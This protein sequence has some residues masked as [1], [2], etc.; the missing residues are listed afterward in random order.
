MENQNA[1]AAELLSNAVYS[2]VQSSNNHYCSLFYGDIYLLAAKQYYYLH[3]YDEMARMDEFGLELCQK[4]AATDTEIYHFLYNIKGLKYLTDRE[5]TAAKKI[6]N[7][8]LADVEKNWGKENA[9]YVEYTNNLAL[10]ALKEGRLA[11]A[12]R[13]LASLAEVQNINLSPS[14]QNL[15][16]NDRFILEQLTADEELEGNVNT[17]YRATAKSMEDSNDQFGVIRMKLTYLFDK[18]QKKK[19]LTEK[20]R[21]IWQELYDIYITKGFESK[22]QE[23]FL[24]FVMILHKWNKDDLSEALSESEK[25]IIDMGEDIYLQSYKDISI[26]H[27]QL[28][29]LNKRCT[30]TEEYLKKAYHKLYEQ[31]TAYGFGDIQTQLLYLRMHLSILI[32]IRNIFSLSGKNNELEEFYKKVVE[33]K[34]IEKE[35]LRILGKYH[36]NDK[37]TSQ[38]LYEFQNV[39]RKIAALK[40][41]KQLLEEDAW[42]KAWDEEIDKYSIRLEELENELQEQIDF[43]KLVPEFSLNAIDMPHD[44]ICVDFFSYYDYDLTDS[45][46]GNKDNPEIKYIAFCVAWQNNKFSVLSCTDISVSENQ[47]YELAELPE[48]TPEE[49]DTKQSASI[50]LYLS[51]KIVL[52]LLDFISPYDTIF[53]GLDFVLQMLPMDVL[54]ESSSTMLSRKN[55]IYVDSIRDV[56]PDLLLNLE[57]TEA[58]ILGNP[59]YNIDDNY[60]QETRSL[61]FSEFECKEIAKL[62]GATPFLGAEAKQQVFREKHQTDLLHISTHGDLTIEHYEDLIFERFLLT[63]SYVI[64]AG[65]EDWLNCR[66]LKEYGNGLITADDFIFTD[67]SDTKLIVL[68]ACKSGIGLVNGFQSLRGLRWAIGIS[69]VQSSVTTLWTVDDFPTAVLMIFFYQN[70][71]ELPVSQALHL[72]K[73]QLRNLNTDDIL[74]DKSL[75]EM[76]QKLSAE[77]KQSLDKDRP[78][79]NWRYWAGFVCYFE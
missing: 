56:H 22:E 64:L 65:F 63:N 39:H 36:G 44:A 73:Q 47:I 46:Y 49:M 32:K 67:L 78:F 5:F 51:E 68:S 75:C 69:G 7:E 17:L 48:Y 3:D 31:I 27:A 13:H 41:R 76:Y 72:A 53:W 55:N 26:T 10:V 60:E 30:E 74:K 45:I 35:L 21:E 23:R 16:D 43:S 15:L 2:Y 59:K 33:S 19:I 40:V 71:R 70:L 62:L 54:L 66:M 77:Y 29:Y 28:L 1:E 18:A 50:I 79:G 37:Q 52:P 38:E 4:L 42:D 6:F 20:D 11:D 9:N 58:L 34:S 8:G 14:C 25:L 12:K 57:E 24:R 61:F